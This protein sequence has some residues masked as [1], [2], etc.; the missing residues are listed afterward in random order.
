MNKFQ[1]IYHNLPEDRD[2]FLPKIRRYLSSA[3]G[4]EEAL[5]LIQKFVDNYNG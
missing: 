1:E 4:Q 2:K 5:F 3:N